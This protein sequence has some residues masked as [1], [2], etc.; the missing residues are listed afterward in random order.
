MVR[1]ASRVS[2]DVGGLRTS[3]LPAALSAALNLT[4]GKRARH[5]LRTNYLRLRL[6]GNV[7][8]DEPL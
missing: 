8:L 4:E 7:L 5:A 2:L 6:A 3:E 1:L